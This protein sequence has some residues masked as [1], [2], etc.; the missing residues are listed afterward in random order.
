MVT[1]GGNI[2]KDFSKPRPAKRDRP[3]LHTALRAGR[4]VLGM[5]VGNGAVK[6]SAEDQVVNFANKQVK[7]FNAKMLIKHA[8]TRIE[9]TYPSPM[10]RA[11]A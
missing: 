2:P 11:G 5:S 6:G 8:S 7:V 10:L 4:E 9:A 1:D 3:G